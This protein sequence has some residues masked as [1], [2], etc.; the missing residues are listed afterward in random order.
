[1]K[2]KFKPEFPSRS[3]I[4]LLVFVDCP[5]IFKR[6]FHFLKIGNVNSQVE[7]DPYTMKTSL[8]HLLP[9][10]LESLLLV[11]C[12]SFPRCSTHNQVCVLKNI[13]PQMVAY[14]MHN[15]EPSIT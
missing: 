1:M 5:I 14:N 11:S 8:S 4:I 12:M 2:M 3:L 10:L 15:F 6:P 13:F 7:K 9:C